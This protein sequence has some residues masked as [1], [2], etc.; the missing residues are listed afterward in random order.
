MRLTMPI[1]EYRC[2]QCNNIEEVIHKVADLNTFQFEC[3]KCGCT[4]GERQISRPAIVYQSPDNS[5]FLGG[6]LTKMDTLNGKT[7][8]KKKVYSGSPSDSTPK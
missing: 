6:S 7:K 2:H 4:G 1:Y 3:S 5:L 8:N